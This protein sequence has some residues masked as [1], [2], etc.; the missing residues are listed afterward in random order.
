MGGSGRDQT[1]SQLV[2][3][4]AAEGRRERRCL[5]RGVESREGRGSFEDRKELHSFMLMG[6]I[7]WEG[8]EPMPDKPFSKGEDLRPDARG[9]WA[10]PGWSVWQQVQ[11]RWLFGGG[12]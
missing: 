4:F 8:G 10:G 6:M 5:E 7:Y 2:R 12:S 3:N 9:A 11:V 1:I